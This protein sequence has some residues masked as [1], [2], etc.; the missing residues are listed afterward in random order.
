MSG[1]FKKTTEIEAE[2][3]TSEIT[4]LLVPRGATGILTDYDTNQRV[5]AVSFKM[6]LGARDV[7][8]RLPCQWRPVLVLLS[9]DTALKAKFKTEDQAVRVAW[10]I[11]HAW[12]EAQMAL[13]DTRMVEMRTVFLP[14]VVMPNGQTLGETVEQ[15]PQ[16]LL[17]E[18]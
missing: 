13:V 17:G 18:K 7:G 14:Y 2:R 11:I 15:N 5:S 8:F 6:Q 12:V 1:I 3:T 16:F 10:R 9:E 4:R